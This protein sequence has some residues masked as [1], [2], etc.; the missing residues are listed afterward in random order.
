MAI[1]YVLNNHDK[2]QYLYLTRAF[3]S[4]EIEHLRGDE[5]TVARNL[6]E[7]CTDK[8]PGYCIWAAHVITEFLRDCKEISL[9]PDEYFL[10]DFEMVPPFMYMTDQDLSEWCQHRGIVPEEYFSG[11]GV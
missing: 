8:R 11:S 10:R 1:E 4:V 3:G 6:R 7:H 9:H 5:R 2:K